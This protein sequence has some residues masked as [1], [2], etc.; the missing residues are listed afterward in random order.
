MPDGTST[1]P[2][3]GVKAIAA[4]RNE[5]KHVTYRGLALGYIAGFKIGGIWHWRPETQAAEY[6]RLE[7]EARRTA[8]ERRANRSPL[9]ERGRRRL[10]G[11]V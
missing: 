3:R 5:P 11:K 1:L 8:E 7:A 6:A 2:I 10:M 9:H 4:A